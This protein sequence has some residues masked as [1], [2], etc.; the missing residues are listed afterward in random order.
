MATL[1]GGFLVPH[2]PLIAANPDAAP[3]EKRRVVLG[4]FATMTR[5]L[6]ELQVDTVVIVGDDHYTLFGPQCLPRCLIGVGEVDGPVEPWLN[7]PRRSIPNDTRLADHILNV[8]MTHD[9]D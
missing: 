4:A 9:V 7:I 8:G 3:P 2:V 5:R 6:R 1:V